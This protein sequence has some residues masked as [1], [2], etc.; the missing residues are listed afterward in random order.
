MSV[1]DQKISNICSNYWY[2]KYFNARFSSDKK[3][4]I[5]NFNFDYVGYRFK[6]YR[7]PAINPLHGNPRT[8]VIFRFNDVIYE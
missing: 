4:L 7:I 6:K 1:D 8:R 3:K 2:N 5:I